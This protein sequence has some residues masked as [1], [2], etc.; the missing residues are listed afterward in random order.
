MK[1]KIFKTTERDNCIKD[2]VEIKTLEELINFCKKQ[3][4]EVIITKE[5]ELEIY[6][7]FRE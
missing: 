6:N 4:E 1:F 5:M 2:I 3:N 7:G